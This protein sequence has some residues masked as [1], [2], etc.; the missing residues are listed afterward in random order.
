MADN[1]IKISPSK[2]DVNGKLLSI[3]ESKIDSLDIDNTDILKY[4]YL[5]YI[6]DALSMAIRDSAFYKTYLDRE[7]HII[8]AT[9]PKKVY[10]YA[11]QFN[12][13]VLFA[14]PASADILFKIPIDDIDSKI[15]QLNNSDNSVN[16]LTIDKKY[17][18]VANNVPFSLEHSIVITRSNDSYIVTYDLNEDNVTSSFGTYSSSIISSSIYTDNGVKY[19]YFT[20]QAYQ[21]KTVTTTKIVSSTSAVNNKVYTF[22]FENQICGISMNCIRNNKTEDVD[23]YFSNMSYDKATTNLYGYYSLKDENTVEIVFKDGTYGLPKNGSKLVFNV[24]ETLGNSG[25]IDYTGDAVINITGSLADM[26]ISV[27]FADGSSIGGADKPTL[28]EIKNKVTNILTTRDTIITTNDLNAYFKTQQQYLSKINNGQISF[29]KERDDL[30]RRSFYA[31]ILM[32]DT[33]KTD[34]ERTVIPTATVDVVVP[35]SF[36]NSTILTLD[37]NSII[38]YNNTKNQYEL[39]SSESGYDIDNVYKIP[40]TT[41]ISLKTYK[42]ASYLYLSTNDSCELLTTSVNK[43][44]A[45]LLPSTIELIKNITDDHYTLNVYVTSDVDLSATN[46][47]TSTEFVKLKIYNGNSATTYSVDSDLISVATISDTDSTSSIKQYKISITINYNSNNMINSEGTFVLSTTSFGTFAESQKIGVII[48]ASSSSSSV[49]IEFTSK[50][51]LSAYETLDDIMNSD[52]NINKTGTGEGATVNSITIT[53]V[54]VVANYWW[55]NSDDDTKLSFVEQLMVYIKIL[56]STYDKLESNTFF[57]LKF[58]NTYS[59]SYNYNCIR[60]NLNLKLNIYLTDSGYVYNNNND[61]SLVKEIRYVI[62]S[63]VDSF[64]NDKELS[65]SRIITVIM[66]SYSSYVSHIE[67]VSLNGTFNQR[68]TYTASSSS[69]IDEF[70][71]LDTTIDSNG[72]NSLEKDILFYY[73]N[74]TV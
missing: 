16:S 32:K 72:V 11:K 58:K 62:K 59:I 33:S 13:D 43:N 56:K 47:K 14:T 67:F 37:K 12:L 40:F 30:L 10:A 50:N 35:T 64:N 17:T 42:K 39:T 69:A 21:Y 22:Y 71:T 4:G 6:T 68:I 24:F 38:A 51:E 60:T 9:T 2:T 8:T 1:T 15:S 19:L 25:N 70:F 23:L 57:N 31:Q 54:P 52:I 66:A 48:Q 44:N 73:N 45:V 26:S 27:S 46:I 18:I 34:L 28:D 20:A 36:I 3:L 7:S 41:I 63:L 61:G 55:N 5:G 49:N 53:K 74:A 29:S 65:V